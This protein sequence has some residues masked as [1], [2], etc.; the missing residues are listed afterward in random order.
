MRHF[1]ALGVGP[2]KV[3]SMDTREMTGVTYRGKPA[4]YSLEVAWAS[5]GSWTLELIASKRGENIYTE[6]REKHGDG[7]HHLGMYLDDY[8]QGY[9]QLIGMGYDQIQGGRLKAWTRLEDSIISTRR[10]ITGRFL[11]FSIFPRILENLNIYIPIQTRLP[12]E[13]ILKPHCV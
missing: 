2:F 13:E 11:S 1:A 7:I 6:F 8:Q 12:D 10:R 9:D 5:L 4:D 3:Y